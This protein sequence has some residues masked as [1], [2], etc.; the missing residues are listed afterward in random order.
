MDSNQY[1]ELINSGQY[2]I[3]V[4]HEEVSTAMAA[5]IHF[6]PIE[7]IFQMGGAT[8]KV[9]NILSRCHAKCR[10]GARGHA[11]PSFGMTPTFQLKIKK[12]SVKI[13]CH[14]KRRMALCS[15]ARPSFFWYDNDSGHKGP[16]RIMQ[17]KSVL[18]SL[19][20]N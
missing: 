7:L 14:S 6:S 2:K 1:E 18:I 11:R 19:V 3:D 10:T 20:L 5:V 4:Y 13:R 12:K 9:P 17:L 8:G 16:F 15:H